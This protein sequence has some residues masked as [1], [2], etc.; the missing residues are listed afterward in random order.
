MRSL[1]YLFVVVA[2]GIA[3][4]SANAA[5]WSP[6]L[7][8]TSDFPVATSVRVSAEAPFGLEL[9]GSLGFLPGPYADA[10]NAFIVSSGGYDQETGQLIRDSLNHSMVVSLG[11]GYGV[12][13]K[14]RFSGNYSHISLGG[15]TTTPEFVATVVGVPLPFA[16][17]DPRQ[18]DVASSLHMLGFEFSWPF[19][20]THLLQ[21]RVGIG[22][23]FTVGA[24]TEVEVE[25]NDS[26]E[27]SLERD[28][29]LYMNDIYRRYAHP[30]VLSVS[31][32]LGF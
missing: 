10:I 16:R 28:A 22:A 21:L 2:Q 1:I 5:P 17:Q 6:T 9:G 26:R 11:A 12:F 15:T 31:F 32:A 30:P 27:A 4:A 13:S 23:R 29:E 14:L 18:V 24:S 3:I 20:L 7:S 8:A 19:E 25:G